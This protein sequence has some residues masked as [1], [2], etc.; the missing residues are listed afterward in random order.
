MSMFGSLAAFAEG[1]EVEADVDEVVGTLSDNIGE[2]P[3]DEADDEAAE[4]EVTG[5]EGAEEEVTDEETAEEEATEEEASAEE[6]ATEEE[7]TEEEA[8]EEEATEEEAV[9]EEATEEEAVEEEATE[10]EVDAQ[11]EKIIIAFA[12]HYGMDVEEAAYEV[13]ILMEI[14]DEF[15]GI[16][17]IS[18]EGSL[19]FEYSVVF[20]VR[21]DGT[22]LIDGENISGGIAEM[23][24]ISED[25]VNEFMIALLDE[26]QNDEDCTIEYS[27]DD[28]IIFSY[29]STIEID[30]D[31]VMY[32]D[33][34]EIPV[35][36]VEDI[37]ADGGD[38]NPIKVVAQ[39][40]NALPTTG[41]ESSNTLIYVGSA[42]VIL[43]LGFIVYKKTFASN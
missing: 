33:G 23:Y 15:G 14:T 41:E 39:D 18:E 40:K 26:L 1:T 35:D 30:K 37:V 22:L 4:E 32:I 12:K 6:E 9:E 5:E 7:A 31:G 11:L 16:Y 13:E 42:L 17:Y 43:G 36:E 38:E 10:E 34:E 3:A 8:V 28:K 20:E 29:T 21:S 25:E 24:G 27:D 19:V 2:D